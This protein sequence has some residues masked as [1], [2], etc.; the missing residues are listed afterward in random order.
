MFAFDG[1][2][3]VLSKLQN[4]QAGQA[5]GK[6]CVDCADGESSTAAAVTALG[7]IGATTLSVVSV[8]WG[9]W[10]HSSPNRGF[11]S[12]PT[13]SAMYTLHRR[14]LLLALCCVAL[15]ASTAFGAPLH[16]LE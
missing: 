11:S 9:V 1:Y 13:W 14:K 16:R 4:R 15:K 12:W 7:P 6:A 2:T 10:R 3:N 8:V 5:G